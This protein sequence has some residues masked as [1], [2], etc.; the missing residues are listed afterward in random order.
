MIVFAEGY[1]S[2]LQLAFEEGMA[3]EVVGDEKGQERPTHKAIEPQHGVANVEVIAGITRTL[4]SEDAAMWILDRK[5]GNGGEEDGPH[6]HAL[7]NEV[8]AELFT[9]LH[10][11]QVGVN[12]VFLAHPFLGPLQGKFA[13][14]GKSLHPAV[15]IMGALTQ[16]FFADGLDLVKVAEEVDEVLWAGE[17]RQMAENDDAVEAEIYAR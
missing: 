16:D 1:A 12:V 11:P 10:A 14:L 8:D 7:E 17:Q 4:S 6:F 3:V 13:F 15:V 5:P 2:A 9:T